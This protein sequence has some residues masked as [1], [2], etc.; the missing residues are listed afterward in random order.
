MSEWIVKH[1]KRGTEYKVLGYA[2]L[3]SGFPVEEGQRLVV[4][5]GDDGKMWVRPAQ[6]FHD[7]RFVTLGEQP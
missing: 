1:L 7:G 2:E 4:Y 6:E 5:C 3:Q